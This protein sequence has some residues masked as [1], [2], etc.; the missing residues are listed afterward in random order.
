MESQAGAQEPWFCAQLRI[1][2]VLDLL[3]ICQIYY[4]ALTESESVAFKIFSRVRR[5]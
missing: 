5:F 1:T 2:L 3:V 4:L